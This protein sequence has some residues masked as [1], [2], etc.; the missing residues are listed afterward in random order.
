MGYVL[1]FGQMS[2][3]GA[4]SNYKFIISF[5]IFNRMGFW[6]TLCLQSNIERGNLSMVILTSGSRYDWFYKSSYTCPMIFLLW[7]RR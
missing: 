5:S 6:R 4:S 2:F 3:W 1:P 7:L